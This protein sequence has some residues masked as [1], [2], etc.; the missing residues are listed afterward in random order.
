MKVLYLESFYGGS[1]RD[2]ADGFCHHSRHDV[3]LH[4]LPARFWKW[5][6]R[7]AA[8]HFAET[9]DPSAYDLVFATSL[10]ALSDLKALWGSTCPPTLFY[11][12]ENQLSYPLPEEG[13]VDLQF[14]FTDITSALAADWVLFNSETHR[15]SFLESIPSFIGNMP[16]F[17]V[18]WVQERLRDTSAVCTPGC[19]FDAVGHHGPGTEGDAPPL[20]VWNH[21][22]EF[23]KQPELFFEALSKAKAQGAAFRLAILGENFQM[24][25]QA[26]LSAR[27]DFA[28]EIIHMGYLESRDAYYDV[29]KR[30][31]VVIS[32]AIQENFGIAMAEAMRYGC[33]PLAPRRLSYPEL[34]PAWAH[35][36]CMYDHEDELVQ[37]IVDI[38]NN[39]VDR[40]LVTALS[41]HMAAF[42]WERRI[43]DFDDWR[44]RVRSRSG[45]TEE[46]LRSEWL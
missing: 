5:R 39:G 14:G 1:H 27:E 15:N 30:G 29:L 9:I 31:D 37:G 6:M 17:R 44:E 8:L 46:A 4:S 13:F 21:R 3:E 28:R 10:T 19:H 35:G 7:G 34:I 11:M 12:H 23:D 32:T 45:D 43:D 2:I 24:K 26:F 25:P 16:E 38:S 18:P 40:G 41:E 20:I 36:A 33:L 22:W 42:A